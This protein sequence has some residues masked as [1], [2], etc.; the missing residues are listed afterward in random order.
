MDD[1]D[2]CYECGGFDGDHASR[3]GEFTKAEN[4]VN[5]RCVLKLETDTSQD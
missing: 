3:P 1:Y 4:N 2:Y 5:C